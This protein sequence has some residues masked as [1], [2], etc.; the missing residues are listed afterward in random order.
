MAN[1]NLFIPILQRIE[2]GFQ[3]LKNDKGNYNSLGQLVGTNYGISAAFYETILKRPPTIA[4]MKAITKKSAE[5]LYKKYFWDDVQG[6]ILKN[7]SIANLIADH[8]VNSGENPIGKIVQKILVNDF[9]K[10]LYVDGDIGVETAKAINS[11]NQQALFEKIKAARYQYYI[12]TGGEF[13]NSWLNRLKNFSYSK[14]DM[15]SES[16]A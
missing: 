9:N 15:P 13:L 12:N 16:V 1:F 8:A 7:Q 4:D 11:V 2:G 6:D 14:N 5:K 10:N 3:Q